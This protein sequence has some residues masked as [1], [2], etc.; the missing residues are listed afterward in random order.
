MRKINKKILISILTSVIVMI[1][2]VATTFAWVGIFTYANTD[3]FSINLKV[4]E[5][6]ANY[7][8]TI[9]ATGERGTFSDEAD[10]LEIKKQVLI[11]IN[12]WN[13]EYIDSKDADE[14]D[15]LYNRYCT[16]KPTT[17]LMTADG[18]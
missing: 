2:I 8:L 9:S 4:S 13:R 14:I 16:T 15:A 5:L 11:N 10:L 7:F 1:T 17:T 3:N 12:N 6:D 18:Q